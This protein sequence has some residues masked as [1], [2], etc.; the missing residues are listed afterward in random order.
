MSDNTRTRLSAREVLL[1]GPGRALGRTTETIVREA[2]QTARI[3]KEAFKRPEPHPA[4]AAESDPE[5]RFQVSLETS[6]RTEAD[7]PELERR[8]G[9][10]FE[11][12]AVLTA[13]LALWTFIAPVLGL[14]GQSGMALFDYFLPVALTV[15]LGTK[16]FAANVALY[17]I[18]RRSMVPIREFL[19]DRSA[20]LGGKP[21]RGASLC[22]AAMAV[23]AG[24]S[25]LLPYPALAQAT[26]QQTQS[27]MAGMFTNA[28]AEDLSLEWL[29]RLFPAMANIACPSSGS[30][31]A[32]DA[33]YLAA[34]MGA[35]NS[36]L[37]GLGAFMLAFHTLVGT[38]NTAHE[39]K[40]MGQR[41]HTTW[42]PIRIVLG[43]GML[44]PIRGYCSIQF[45]ILFV[46]VMGYNL[47]NSL[48]VSYVER[49]FSGEMASVAVTMRPNLGLDLA[50]SVLASETCHAVLRAHG[51]GV[52][53]QRRHTTP[54]SLIR[55]SQMPEMAQPAPSG[56]GDASG[57]WVWNYGTICGAIRTEAP[58][59]PLASWQPQ[60]QTQRAITE[61]SVEA[62]NQAYR[63]F[64]TTRDQAVGTLISSVREANLAG[65]IA[66]AVLPNVRPDGS[67]GV[68]QEAAQDIAREVAQRY[69]Q[70]RS[71]GQAFDNSINEAARTMTQAVNAQGSSGFMSRAQSLGWAS[72]GALNTTLLRAAA[73]ASELTA[74][75]APGA[76][77]PD[78][79]VLARTLAGSRSPEAQQRLTAAMEYLRGVLTDYDVRGTATPNQIAI[80]ADMQSRNMIAQF[81]KPVTDAITRA[82]TDRI[83]YMDPVRPMSSIQAMGN[84]MLTIGQTMFGLW[85]VANMA[86]EGSANSAL[87]LVGAGA[88]KGLVGAVG[89]LYIPIMIAT[90]ICGALHAYILPMLPFIIWAYA[91]IAVISLAAELVIAGPVAAFMHIRADGNDF[92]NQE[93]KTIYTMLFNAL[94]RPSLLLCGLVVANLVLSI[95]ASYLNRL[96]GVAV[97]TTNGDGIIGLVGWITMTIMVFYLH[98]QLVVRSMSLITAVP[99]AVSELIGA[100]D[101]DRGDVQEGNR[102]F[103]AVANVTQRGTQTALTSSIAGAAKNKESEQ[104]VTEQAIGGRQAAVRQSGTPNAGGGQGGQGGGNRPASGPRQVPP[105]KGKD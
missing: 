75:A 2:Q 23:G 80:G 42:A 83:G 87:G 14:G 104:A 11:I 1:P 105:A 71:A 47:A 90:I 65:Y 35:L 15:L 102:V 86:A 59:D 56:V 100:R 93:Q 58:T 46:I 66:S 36:A 89:A 85:A 30:C 64:L 88:G 78:P 8:A 37:F 20:W 62:A 6:G 82:G 79:T 40:V 95:M 7:L 57:A 32:S 9:R 67:L 38:V 53:Q 33:D 63:Q 61:R 55:A 3:V 72:A 74:S 41:W 96:Y 91:I 69:A 103:A 43:T 4:V 48:W 76:Q 25:A 52:A 26:I 10:A 99:A 49:A 39:G 70:V 92:I 51:A 81:V 50:H 18:Q 77:G 98:Y 45:A 21:S 44:I 54:S 84:T 19:R 24:L 28:G 16:A 31:A 97:T 5:R 17:R 101:Q 29:R 12:Y 73:R 27:A 13:F 22:L 34:M 94:L 60:G 68:S